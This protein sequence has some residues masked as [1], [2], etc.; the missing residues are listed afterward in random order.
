MMP[1][2]LTPPLGPAR[3]GDR[4]H[5]W[6][7]SGAEDAT[8]Y[9]ARVQVGGP[10]DRRQP[11]CSEA[12]PAGS[13]DVLAQPPALLADGRQATTRDRFGSAAGRDGVQI[14]LPPGV[15]ACRRSRLKLL[16]TIVRNNQSPIR[17]QMDGELGRCGSSSDC[18][19]HRQPEPPHRLSRE[20]SPARHRPGGRP[21]CR[22]YGDWTSCA[23]ADA[24]RS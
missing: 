18:H 1:S 23:A 2:P 9:G 14:G 17:R 16:S 24:P 5:R 8:H 19:R 3:V 20:H 13:G 7:R 15:T 6:Q 22:S 4:A 21:C 10:P 12:R 11:G